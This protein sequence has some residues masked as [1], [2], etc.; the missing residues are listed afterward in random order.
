MALV[1]ITLTHSL[2]PRCSGNFQDHSSS[3]ASYDVLSNTQQGD[4]PS[5]QEVYARSD[6]NLCGRRSQVDPS[7]SCTGVCINLVISLCLLV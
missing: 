5:L 6:G 3:Q 7:W 2:I 1:S 4:P